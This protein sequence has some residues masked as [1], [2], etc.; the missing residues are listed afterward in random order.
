MRR[1]VVL[2]RPRAV[3]IREASV[4]PWLNPSTLTNKPAQTTTQTPLQQTESMKAVQN[5]ITEWAMKGLSYS[6]VLGNGES[7]GKT[8]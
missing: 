4:A 6:V 5:G 3:H 7:F 2:N 1:K 8:L